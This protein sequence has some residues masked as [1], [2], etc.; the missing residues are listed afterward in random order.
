[1]NQVVR[2]ARLSL[3]F[4]VKSAQSELIS[5]GGNWQAHLNT[6]HYTGGW[7]V[8][9]LRSPGGKHDNPVP[10]LMGETGH[11]DTF[12][13]DQFPSVKALTRTLECPVMSVRF[14]HLK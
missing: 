5:T 4:D 6:Y 7:E 11:A 1:M 3:A 14:L 13:M 9:P 2:Y 12:Y 8:L 10:D